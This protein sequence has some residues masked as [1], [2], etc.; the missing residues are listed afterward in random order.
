MRFPMAR[1]DQILS[2]FSKIALKQRL[3]IQFK[4]IKELNNVYISVYKELNLLGSEI[5]MQI[6]I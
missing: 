3:L 1:A 6:I 4:T 5:S 2:K